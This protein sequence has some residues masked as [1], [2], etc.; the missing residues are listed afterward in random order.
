[1]KEFVAIVKS[2]NGVLEKY[3][4]FDTEQK[5]LD[6]VEVFGGWIAPHPGGDNIHYWVI[7]EAAKTL[8]YD[9][10]KQDKDQVMANWVIEIRATDKAMTRQ[11]EDYIDDQVVVLKP[12]RTKDAY[13]AK[14]VVRARRP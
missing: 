5:A 7:D 4:S 2:T 10:I 13:D 11:V 1:M 6:H 8:G 12:G 9:Q 14:K 3:S